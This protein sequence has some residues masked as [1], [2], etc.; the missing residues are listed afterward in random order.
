MLVNSQI[1][2]RW[3]LSRFTLM[4]RKVFVGFNLI[5]NE[6]WDVV[7]NLFFQSLGR[8]TYVH[9]IAVAQVFVYNITSLFSR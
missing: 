7:S 6:F 3:I 9:T 1:Q 2:N 5:S 8:S 4:S